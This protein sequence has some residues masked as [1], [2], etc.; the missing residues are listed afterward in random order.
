MDSFAL[1]LFHPLHDSDK[2]GDLHG[3]AV[4][5]RDY[6]SALQRISLAERYIESKLSVALELCPKR[7]SLLKVVRSRKLNVQ[8]VNAPVFILQFHALKRGDSDHWNQEMVFVA[9]VELVEGVNIAVPSIVRLYAIDYK[10]KKGA[11]VWYLSAHSRLKVFPRLF[12]IN[13]KL[14]EFGVSTG[15]QGAI[16]RTP[17]NIQSAMQIVNCVSDYQG[18]IACQGAVGKAVID[19]LFPRLRIDVQAGAVAIQRSAESLLDIG[20]MLLSPFDF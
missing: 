11:G 18:D 10:I 15:D 14:A 9:N 12:W 16:C 1:P 17:S 8:S 4:E 7:D 6:L 19:E 20:D 2:P 5:G 3:E 13:G